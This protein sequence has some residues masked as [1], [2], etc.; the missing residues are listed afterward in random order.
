MRAQELPAD[1]DIT[2][3]GGHLYD[4]PP[5]PLRPIFH[6]TTPA[7][8]PCHFR[9]R[10]YAPIVPQQLIS[11]SPHV[12]I[13]LTITRQRLKILPPIFLLFQLLLFST[14]ISIEFDG[15]MMT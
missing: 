10:R 15:H 6:V 11:P 9:R 14:T 5:T 1:D 2:L 12:L 7:S 4:M 3:P 8:S 13:S